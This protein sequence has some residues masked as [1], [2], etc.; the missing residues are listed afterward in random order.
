MTTPSLEV[1]NLWVGDGAGATVRGVSF[2]ANPGEVIGI[3]GGAG[4]G[5]SRL[6]RCLGLDYLP[7]AGAIII[8]GIDVA[9]CGTDQRRQLRTTHVEL[10]HP[11]VSAEAAPPTPVD[12][13]PLR[14]T[15]PAAGVR[16]RIQIARALTNGKQLVL[17]DEPFFGV[18]DA[19]RER[20]LE[21]LGRLCGDVQATV[22]LASQDGELCRQLADRVLEMRGGA[23]VATYEGRSGL[24]PRVRP[25]SRWRTSRL[26]SA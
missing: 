2:A 4:A 23:V 11:P 25:R 26:R 8:G 10:V 15:I 16:Q 12:G 24:A 9:R 19:V 21:L 17:L 7:S 22:V 5:K 18:E 20:I 14:P 1:R 3:T 6:L 13:T